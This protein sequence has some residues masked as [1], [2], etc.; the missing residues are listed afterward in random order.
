MIRLKGEGAEEDHPLKMETRLL[1]AR[2][3]RLL[4]VLI[5]TSQQSDGA[6]DPSVKS[7]N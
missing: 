7:S 3:T 4:R 1:R 6:G 2:Q 5:E